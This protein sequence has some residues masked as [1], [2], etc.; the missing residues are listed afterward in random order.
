[1]AVAGQVN[2]VFAFVTGLG[3]WRRHLCAFLAGALAAAALAPVYVVPVLLISV[4]CLVLLIDGCRRPLQAFAVGWWFGLGYFV[5]GLYWLANAFLVDAETYAWLIPLAVFVLPSILAIFTGAAMAAARMAWSAGPERIL[6]L[7]L[8]WSAGEWLRG[9]LFTGFP[10]N[11]F[12]YVW[13]FSDAMIQTTAVVGIYGLSLLTVAIA[14][15]PATLAGRD[16]AR[17]ASWRFVL[18]A[19]AL[20]LLLFSAGAIRIAA[21]EIETVAGV[22]LRLVQANIPQDQ[23][24]LPDKRRDNFVR[25]LTM[26]EASRS[27]RVSHV[28]WPETAVPYFIAGEPSRRSLIGRVSPPGGMVLTG[29]V[30]LRREGSTVAEL[31]NSFHAIGP[32]GDIIGTYDKSHLVPFGEYLP[33]RGLL[34]WFG[35][36]KLVPGGSDFSAGQGVRT[37]RLPGLPPVSVLICYEAIFPGAVADRDDRPA[38]L[39]NITNDAWY[40]HSAGP[41]QHLAMT[42]VRAVEEGIPLVR[43]ASTGIS[44]V[45]DPLGRIVKSI[46]LGKRGVVDSELPVALTQAPPYARLGDLMFLALVLAMGIAGWASVKRRKA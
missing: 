43:A 41:Y 32:K 29:A 4:P 26:S 7:A 21:T 46:G 30:R 11:L 8:A 3:G 2:S 36:S 34:E 17:V 19:T 6:T 20:C 38:W 28:I 9:H 12:G 42:R 35:I 25:H 14:A 18:G 23:K 44:A 1:M 15:S 31:W 39:L 27:D 10:W 24:W 40:G 33:M 16:L 5:A 13:T 45:V 37:L 22:E